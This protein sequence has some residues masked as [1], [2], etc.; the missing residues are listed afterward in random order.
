SFAK[1]SVV[2][3]GGGFVLPY[4]TGYFEQISQRL[5]E[6]IA[7]QYSPQL[8]GLKQ[9]IEQYGV[10]YLL[11]DQ[12]FTDVTYLSED[13]FLQYPIMRQ[14][15]LERLGEGRLPALARV[16][17]NCVVI[18]VDNVKPVKLLDASCILEQ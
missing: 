6:N 4:H 9:F 14:R 11:I 13:V 3:G 15:L 18:E 7:A 10:D 16:A 5:L 12:D 17:P 8:D 2:V 1:R